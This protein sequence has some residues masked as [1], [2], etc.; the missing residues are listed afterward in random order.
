MSEGFRLFI[1]TTAVLAGVALVTNRHQIRATWTT[2]TTAVLATAWLL[3][4]RHVVAAILSDFYLVVERTARTNFGVVYGERADLADRVAVVALILGG[5]LLVLH[6]LRAAAPL[7]PAGLIAALTATIVLASTFFNGLVPE[8]AQALAVIVVMALAATC[9]PGPGAILGA[10][11]YGATLTIVSAV[12]LAFREDAAVR[13]CGAKCGPLGQL[14]T[15]AFVNENAF[16]LSAAIALPFVLLAFDGW[17]RLA[18]VLALSVAVAGSESR[19]AQVAMLATGV[20][21]LATRGRNARPLATAA[22]AFTAGAAL[23]IPLMI[24]ERSSQAFTGRGY[25]WWVAIQG[26]TEHWTLGLGGPAWRQVRASTLAV[27]EEAVYSPHNQW[28]DILFAGGALAA[29][30]LALLLVTMY[31]SAIPQDQVAVCLVIVAVMVTGIGERPWSFAAPDWLF[32]S[33]LAGCLVAR[34]SI[35]QSPPSMTLTRDRSL[36]R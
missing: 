34:Q 30:G 8:L 33:L 16:G 6:R 26:W 22:A 5:S 25:V 2:S 18:M 4:T 32:W 12:L 3:N 17:R 15:G 9:L 28:L 19:T 10:A 27:G 1:L 13:P 14:Y 36:R 21:F 11:L 20:M 35:E 7:N 23:L 29:A 24:A 31:R